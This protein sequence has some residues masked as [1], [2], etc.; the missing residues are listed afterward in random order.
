MADS[1]LGAPDRAEANH[2]E[3]ARLVDSLSDDALGGYLEAAAWL[4]GVE[5]YLDRLPPARPTPAAHWPWSG[6]P[7]RGSSISS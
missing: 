2:A 1:L 5:L 4:A 3:A 6:P 7:A